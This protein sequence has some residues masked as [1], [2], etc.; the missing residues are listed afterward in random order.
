[1]DV[2]RWGEWLLL[3]TDGAAQVK[4]R[5]VR[6]IRMWLGYDQQA[7]CSRLRRLGQQ[8]MAMYCCL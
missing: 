2:L 6:A 1:M 7:A 8:R 5:P 4:H 3:R